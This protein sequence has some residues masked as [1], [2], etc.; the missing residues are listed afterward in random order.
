MTQKAQSSEVQ[1]TL[2]LR[3]QGTR[4][5]GVGLVAAKRSLARGRLAE[6]W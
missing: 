5:I 4:W 3:F 2:G 1:K 6:L